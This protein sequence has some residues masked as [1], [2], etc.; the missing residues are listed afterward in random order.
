MN[1]MYTVNIITFTF[2]PI[3]FKLIFTL[4]QSYLYRKSTKSMVPRRA[5]AAPEP[6]AAHTPRNNKAHSV[7]LIC[8]MIMKY[9]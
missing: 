5:A 6:V 1:F 3:L 4:L 2:I 7:A 9:L 8:K